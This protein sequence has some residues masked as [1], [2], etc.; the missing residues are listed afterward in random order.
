MD[1]L[2]EQS[3]TLVY[4]QLMLKWTRPAPASMDVP[5]QEMLSVR[6]LLVDG[7]KGMTVAGHLQH[8]MLNHV[9]LNGKGRGKQLFSIVVGDNCIVSR[10]LARTLRVPLIA[11]DSHKQAEVCGED[12]DP[13]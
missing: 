9:E 8:I 12:V 11:C 6:L 1:A 13:E 10:S 7:T 2:K 3:I 5:V 4:L